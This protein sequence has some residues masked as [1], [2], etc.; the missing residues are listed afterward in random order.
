MMKYYQFDETQPAIIPLTREIE[1]RHQAQQEW[2]SC[3]RDFFY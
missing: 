3:L 2:M 1:D